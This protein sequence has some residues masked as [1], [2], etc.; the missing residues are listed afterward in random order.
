M[1]RASQERGGEDIDF[2]CTARPWMGSNSTF[3][4]YHALET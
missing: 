2:W 3:C 1:R 4:F